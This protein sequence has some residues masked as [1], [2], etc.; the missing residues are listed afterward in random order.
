M[1]SAIKFKEDQQLSK[2]VNSFF[3]EYFNFVAFVILLFI[4]IL[5]CLIFILP[6][7]KSVSKEINDAKLHQE[8]TIFKQKSYLAQLNRLNVTYGKITDEQKNKINK[9]LPEE[10]EAEKL[11]AQLEVLMRENGVP[12]SSLFVK[13]DEEKSENLNNKDIAEVN[14][15][16]SLA[17]LNYNTIKNLLNSIENNLRILDV[18][19]LQFSPEGGP[20]SLEIVAYYLK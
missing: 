1:K 16:I 12:I 15:S 3:I 14:I 10:P 6:K 2:K 4:L 9:L 7:Y 8:E 19:S 18:R 11:M 5:G 17:G 20:A 13:F